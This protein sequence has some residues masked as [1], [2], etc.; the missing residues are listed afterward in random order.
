MR[1]HRTCHKC[2]ASFGSN[3]VCSGCQHVRCDQ[4]PRYPKKKVTGDKGK[5]VQTQ[6]GRKGPV[7]GASHDI[8]GLKRKHRYVLTIP[9][10]TGGQDLVSKKP[11]QRVRRNCHLCSTVYRSGNKTCSKC[12]HIRCTDC[13]R[14]PYVPLPSPVYCYIT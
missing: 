12:G 3:K 4:C 9:S 11:T 7:A 1:I 14:D 2:R 6:D 10:K 5:G 8:E 13:P